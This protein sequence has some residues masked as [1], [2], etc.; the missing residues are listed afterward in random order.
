LHL[1]VEVSE[2]TRATQDAKSGITRSGKR[3]P[4]E[5]CSQPSRQEEKADS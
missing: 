3:A 5:N 1:E 2:A 4:E